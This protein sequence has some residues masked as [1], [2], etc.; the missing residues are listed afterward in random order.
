MNTTRYTLIFR[1]KD[2]LNENAWKE[3]SEAYKDYIDAVLQKFGTNQDEVSDLRQDILLKLWK[4]L[5]N[6][7]Y[8]PDKAKFRT[9]LYQII[10][11]TAYTYFKSSESYRQRNHRFFEERQDGVNLLDQLM[12]DEWKAFI[13]R[14]ALN[15][16]RGA[17]ADQSVELFES[18]LSGSSVQELASA[19]SLKEN[20]VYRIKNRVKERLIVE[21]RRLR[22]E[23]E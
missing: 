11:N 22:H 23:M 7:E 4:R 19:Y 9:W 13:C 12:N 3:F 8:E 16:L 14:K 18:F 15:N 10:R 17:F 20:T 21:V 1:V 6:F 5:P 2:P